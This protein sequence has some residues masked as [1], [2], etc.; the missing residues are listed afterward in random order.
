M[1]HDEYYGNVFLWVSFIY[2]DRTPWWLMMRENAKKWLFYLE[3]GERWL[4]IPDLY[5]DTSSDIPAFTKIPCLSHLDWWVLCD[6]LPAM[7]PESFLEAGFCRWNIYTC[8]R[9]ALTPPS[10]PCPTAAWTDIN[11]AVIQWL[12]VAIVLCVSGVMEC[13]KAKQKHRLFFWVLVVSM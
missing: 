5:Q 1:E 2:C 9:F 10:M 6:Y 3:V 4:L 12:K 7:L 13:A 11:R 8:S